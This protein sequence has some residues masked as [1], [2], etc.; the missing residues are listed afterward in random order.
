MTF[1]FQCQ[2]PNTSMRASIQLFPLLPS[3]VVPVYGRS[4]ACRARRAEERLPD[5]QPNHKIGTTTRQ[6]QAPETIGVL[7]C[8]PRLSRYQHH[9]HGTALVNACSLSFKSSLAS[10]RNGERPQALRRIF[11][12]SI[13]SALA[14]RHDCRT[15]HV[16]RFFVAAPLLEG[17][18]FKIF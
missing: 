12:V 13:H 5:E 4:L 14:A 7:V 10:R 9:P 18:N 17:H 1:F 8:R 2:P 11:T 15:W 3:G 6:R 16:L